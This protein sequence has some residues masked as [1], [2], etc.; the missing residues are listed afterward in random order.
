MNLSP[1]L[2]RPA[3]IAAAVLLVPSVAPA[4][5]AQYPRVPP[6]HADL[7][8]TVLIV[9]AGL[10][11]CARFPVNAAL[12]K[13]RMGQVAA[14]ILDIGLAALALV[15][16]RGFGASYRATHEIRGVPDYWPVYFLVPIVVGLGLRMLW[17]AWRGRRPFE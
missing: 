9:I 14:G 17:A 13:T 5:R 6:G 15:F 1:R 16:L 10:A 7:S 11:V 8:A 3:L 2:F 4:Q 12:G